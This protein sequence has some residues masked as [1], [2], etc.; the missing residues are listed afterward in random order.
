ME[1]IKINNNESCME[2]NMARMCKNTDA[3]VNFLPEIRQNILDLAHDL[4]FEGLNER[5][6]LDLL[7]ADR[8]PLSY[9]ELIQL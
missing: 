6:V 4:G 1:G 3:E 2:K 7:E 5:D 9:E 8:E